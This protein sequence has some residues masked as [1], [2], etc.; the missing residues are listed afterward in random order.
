MVRAALLRLHWTEHWTERIQQGHAYDEK[1]MR[2]RDV[3]ACGVLEDVM[4]GMNKEWQDREK[5]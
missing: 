2:E 3:A 5:A 1:M 4:G